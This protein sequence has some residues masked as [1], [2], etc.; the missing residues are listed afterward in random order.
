MTNV[1]WSVNALAAV[2]LAAVALLAAAYVGALGRWLFF[3]L[4]TTTTFSLFLCFFS[5]EAAEGALHDQSAE[6]QAPS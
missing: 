5:G 3:G 1:F 6:P 2:A 4:L